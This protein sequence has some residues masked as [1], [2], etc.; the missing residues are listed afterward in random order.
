VSDDRHP[1]TTVVVVKSTTADAY[2]E[3][4]VGGLPACGG[5]N[6]NHDYVTETLEYARQRWLEPCQK[7][8]C[9]AARERDGPLDRHE[10]DVDMSDSADL[11]FGTE[12]PD[13]EQLERAYWDYYWTLAEI[14]Q[15]IGSYGKTVSSEMENHNIPTR[16]NSESQIV[17]NM[18]GRGESLEAITEEVPHP[19]RRQASDSDDSRFSDETTVES[20]EHVPPEC[21]E[22]NT[23]S[24]H[25]EDI[26]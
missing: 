4:D 15:W 25:W 16:S 20:A 3:V 19:S 5:T 18:K 21:T 26:T 22:S 8:P 13:A 10:R 1:N 9:V 2:H 23:N 12:W 17:S 6:P 7:S 11:F 24:I 14:G